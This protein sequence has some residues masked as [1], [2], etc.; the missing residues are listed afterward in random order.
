MPRKTIAGL[1]RTIGGL[2]MEI[3]KLK[4][5]ATEAEEA[6]LQISIT[7]PDRI[8]LTA[9]QQAFILE[10]N[11]K[12]GQF[13]DSFTEAAELLPRLRAVLNGEG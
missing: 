13:H 3:A 7:H 9:F 8:R 10:H 12:D 5:L 1:E 4:K 2:K 6:E 11:L